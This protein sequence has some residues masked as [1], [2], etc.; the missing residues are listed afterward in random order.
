MSHIGEQEDGTWVLGNEAFFSED[1]RSIPS[2]NSKYVWL[3]S[4]FRAVGVA[5]EYQQCQIEFPLSTD[6]LAQLLNTLR[7]SMAHNFYPF[8]LTMAGMYIIIYIT[9]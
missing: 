4:M 3:G 5:S 9:Q 2:S 6:L 1:G 8:L 7:S